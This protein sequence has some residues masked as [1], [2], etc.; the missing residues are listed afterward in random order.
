MG[1]CCSNATT[2]EESEI[3]TDFLPASSVTNF[4]SNPSKTNPEDAP[5]SFETEFFHRLTSQGIEIM[6]IPGARTGIM[7]RIRFDVKGTRFVLR[8]DNLTRPINLSSIQRVMHT[9]KD[10]RRVQD[11]A[12]LADDDHCCALLFKSQSCISMRFVALQDKIDFI[13]ITKDLLQYYHS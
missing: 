4:G 11:Q 3:Q 7:C 1:S 6:V 9:K 5:A 8:K 13:D 12:V 2:E 10:L